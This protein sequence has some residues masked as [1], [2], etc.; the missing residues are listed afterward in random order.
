MFLGVTPISLHDFTTIFYYKKGFLI[1]IFQRRKSRN[2]LTDKFRTTSA[3]RAFF[4]ERK[5]TGSPA[6]SILSNA[7]KSVENYG[8]F[9]LSFG[10]FL[11][12]YIANKEKEKYIKKNLS[13]QKSLYFFLLWKSKKKKVTK[14]KKLLL[15]STTCRLWIKW[16]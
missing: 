6:T 14:K 16:I 2:Y 10:T 3:P 5:R 11:S 1:K 4:S 15:F 12:L 7:R 8:V 13:F 9:S